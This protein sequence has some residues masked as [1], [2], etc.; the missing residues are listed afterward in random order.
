MDTLFRDVRFGLKLLLKERTF[1]A[2]VLTSARCQARSSGS[3]YRFRPDCPGKSWFSPD[4]CPTSKEGI[5]PIPSAWHRSKS[6]PR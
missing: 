4:M 1:S 6:C 5:A 3:E 2:T